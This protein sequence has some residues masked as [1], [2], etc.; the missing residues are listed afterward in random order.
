MSYQKITSNNVTPVAQEKFCWIRCLPDAL[1]IS[2]LYDIGS[3]YYI[4]AL[5]D[6]FE[7]LRPN[8]VFLV[9]GK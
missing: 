2:C 8:Y 6:P 5:I 3:L 7:A 4:Y 9:R 1:E